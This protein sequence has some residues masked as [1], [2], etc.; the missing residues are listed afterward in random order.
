MTGK[1]SRGSEL[2]KESRLK[3]GKDKGAH[4]EA[5]PDVEKFLQDEKFLKL[6]DIMKRVGKAHS[7]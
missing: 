7:K 1:Y 6:I 2:P 5:V 3:W 4:S